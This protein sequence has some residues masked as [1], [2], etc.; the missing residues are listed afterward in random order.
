MP[1]LQT[2]FCRGQRRRNSPMQSVDL[3]DVMASTAR[4]D[5]PAT[6][7]LACFGHLVRE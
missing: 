6:L 1:A 5:A 7:D 3:R 4:F 2:A